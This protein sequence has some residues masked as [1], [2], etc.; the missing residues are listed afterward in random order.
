[1]LTPNTTEFKYVLYGSMGASS[2]TTSVSHVASNIYSWISYISYLVCYQNKCTYKYLTNSLYY[3]IHTRLQLSPAHSFFRIILWY[4][5][6]IYISFIT[7]TFDKP[8]D[9]K[10]I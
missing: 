4:V 5:H 8:F 10:T 6:H 7:S 3:W 9:K 1:M 2:A